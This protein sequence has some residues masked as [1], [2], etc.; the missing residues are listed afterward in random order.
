MLNYSLDEIAVSSKDAKPIEFP[1][2]VIYEAFGV[3]IKVNKNGTVEVSNAKKISFES[4][5]LNFKAKNINLDATKSFNLNVKGTAYIGSSDHIIQQAPRI[6]FNPYCDGPHGK[7]FSGYFAK[8]K[9]LVLEMFK[10]MGN[11]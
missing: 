10:K 11:K 6:D 7:S 1:T 3:K 8:G 5:D 9:N 2:S 4:D